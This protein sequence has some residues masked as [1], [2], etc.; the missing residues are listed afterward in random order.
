MTTTFHNISSRPGRRRRPPFSYTIRLLAA[1]LV[2]LA[3]SCGKRGDPLPPLRRHPEPVQQLSVSQRGPF[4]QLEWSAPTRNTDGSS[5]VE[6]LKVEV[7]RRILDIVKPPDVPVE[8]LDEEIGEEG[9][10]PEVSEAK[11]EET[12][13]E[14]KVEEKAPPAETLVAQ[15]EATTDQ[16][17]ETPTEALPVAPPAPV[18]PP[19][20]EGATVIA[21]LDSLTGGEGL[22]YRDPWDPSFEGKKLEYAVRH[23]NRKGRTS[24]MS[25]I[26]QI[27]PL[28]PIERPA[29]VQAEVD[30]GGVHIGWV[31][32]PQTR[33][34][35][36]ELGFNIYRRQEGEL[37][38]AAPMNPQAVT[39]STYTDQSAEFGKEW[40]YVVRTVFVPHPEEPT[41]PESPVEV[42]EAIVPP[43]V[44]TPRPP[45]ALIESL[46][47]EEAC[48]TPVDSFAP[49]APTHLIAVEVS[50]GILLSWESVEAE[51]LGGYL[52]YRA[53]DGDDSFALLTPEPISIASYTDRDVE[54][55]VEYHYT[56]SAVD[57]SEPPN[58]SPQ[59]PSVSARA[60]EG[61]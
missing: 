34:D 1:S 13:P 4:V 37:Y 46:D 53:T 45:P 18:I 8:V 57:Q 26:A 43:V 51:D 35:E 5:E 44:P 40:C 30:A 21:T 7:F 31:P 39:T 9:E 41:A 50:E 56:V 28:V 11:T 24:G 38:P 6:L 58:E 33:D 2:V 27:Q 54:P 3:V 42:E 49:A 61:N 60:P 19:F 20:P 25:F 12:L 48:I 29:D 17:A 36:G 55:G 15:E 10:A 23:S 52:V 14:E 32:H 22:S 59:S 47:S 16:E